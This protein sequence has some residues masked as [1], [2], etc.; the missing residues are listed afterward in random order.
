M[1]LY[2]PSLCAQL[3]EEKQLPSVTLSQRVNSFTRLELLEVDSPYE[4]KLQNSL[5]V[6]FF[7]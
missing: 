4:K 2:E 3:L 1:S 7:H 6:S 5:C